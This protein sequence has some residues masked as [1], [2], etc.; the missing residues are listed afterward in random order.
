MMWPDNTITQECMQLLV[1]SIGG[2]VLSMLVSK[3]WKG[4]LGRGVRQK[5]PLLRERLSEN[6]RRLGEKGRA[7]E[8]TFVWLTSACILAWLCIYAY[9]SRVTKVTEHNI[10][11]YRQLQNG[12]W[13]MSS[14]EERGLVFRPCPDDLAH[15]VDVDA[16]LRQASIADN[17]GKGYIADYASWEERGTCKS[18]LRV[19]L[20]FWFRTEKHNFEYRRTEQ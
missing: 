17:Q 4:G 13:A 8:V 16:I 14:D 5:L 3:L 12:D 1:F 15:G 19:D 20:G 10:V 7:S 6:L 11:V 18:I 2:Y 9:G